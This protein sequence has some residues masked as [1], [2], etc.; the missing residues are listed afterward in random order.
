MLEIDKY[1]HLRLLM[2]LTAHK[3]WN[4]QNQQKDQK[5]KT[6]QLH[7]PFVEMEFQN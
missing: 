6:V 3:A 2:I 1:G 7:R 5:Q 4:I